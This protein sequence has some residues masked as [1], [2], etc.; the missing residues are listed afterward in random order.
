MDIFDVLE[1]NKIKERLLLSNINA[2]SSKKISLIKPYYDDEIIQ[3]EIDKTKEG[4]LL[5]SLGTVNV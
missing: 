5:V 4:Y 3:E 2:L 1:F